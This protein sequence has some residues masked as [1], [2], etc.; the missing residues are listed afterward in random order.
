MGALRPRRRFLDSGS[1][2]GGPAL[3]PVRYSMQPIRVRNKGRSTHILI[4]ICTAITVQLV[5]REIRI[6]ASADEVIANGV[7]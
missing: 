4:R 6:M 3:R 5:P 7:V 2:G 1:H